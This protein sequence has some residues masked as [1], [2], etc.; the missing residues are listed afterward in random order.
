MVTFIRRGLWQR[1]KI[2]MGT[3]PSC[4]L[5]G[6]NLSFYALFSIS[7]WFCSVPS[8][9]FS[10]QINYFHNYLANMPKIQILAMIRS[11][12]TQ[13]QG[14]FYAL[15]ENSRTFRSPCNFHNPSNSTK[16]VFEIKI[17]HFFT[18]PYHFGTVISGTEKLTTFLK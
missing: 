8:C 7:N 1:T 4:T 9:S 13:L 12:K 10:R 15:F 16:T 14:H 2:H 6:R 18:L 11:L 5:T 3:L 17:L